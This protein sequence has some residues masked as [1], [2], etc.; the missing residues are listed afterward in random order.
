MND[1][2]LVGGAYGESSIGAI[3]I[4]NLSTW[5]YQKYASSSVTSANFGWTCAIN[6]GNTYNNNTFAF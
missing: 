6:N 5:S 3:Y 4:Y 1:S 2:W